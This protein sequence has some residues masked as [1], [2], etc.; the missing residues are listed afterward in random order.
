MGIS[1]LNYCKC[2]HEKEMHKG[3]SKLSIATYCRQCPCSSY[4]N[5]KRPFKSDYVF[6]GF[7]I[8]VAAAILI[9][10]F[11]FLTEADPAMQGKQNMT[12]T[13]T[14]G[15]LHE[16]MILVFVMINVFMLSW[17]VAD[18]ILDILHAR[19]RK[20]FPLDDKHDQS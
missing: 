16:I 10:S 7:S 15:Q 3:K 19:K 18:P 8:V 14:L 1:K 11:V 9:A 17:L 5:R 6:T 20:E 4:M 12:M 2:G 13:F